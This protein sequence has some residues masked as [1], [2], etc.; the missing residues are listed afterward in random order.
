MTWNFRV[1]PKLG[2]FHLNVSKRG[3]RSVSFTLGP[4]TRNLRTGRSSIDT[5]GPGSLQF[6]G[7]RRGQRQTGSGI[8]FVLG[9]LFCTG[10]L[11][12]AAGVVLYEM[13]LRH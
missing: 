1:R 12:L 7:N 11:A 5:P 4:Y 13:F 3:L 8:R 10:M 9:F 2:P 6:G